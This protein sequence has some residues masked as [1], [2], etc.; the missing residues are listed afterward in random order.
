MIAKFPT[1]ADGRKDGAACAT[2]A[3][4]QEVI[5]AVRAIRSEFAVAPSRGISMVVR[6]DDADLAALISESGALLAA[7][8]RVDVASTI[9]TD[10]PRPPG[11]ATA[12]IRDAELL[13]PL[14]GLIDLDAE[15]ARLA[16]EKERA[17]KDI[18][19]ADKKLSNE[20]FTAKA[21]ADVVAKERERKAE[22]LARLAKVAE[23]IARL[24]EVR[25]A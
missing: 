6:T 17:E 1:A 23:A 5:S 20:R 16:K 13:V 11:S 25:R 14:K 7:L 9:Q 3:R 10:A 15:A 8:A 21:P 12:V 19:F 4:L 2:A 24:D 22:A 18:E